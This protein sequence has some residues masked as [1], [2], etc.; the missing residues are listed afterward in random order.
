MAFYVGYDA[1]K[2]DPYC[3]KRV[4]A[5]FTGTPLNVLTCAPFNDPGWKNWI[6]WFKTRKLA[7]DFIDE[8]YTREENRSKLQ[9]Y[10]VKE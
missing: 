10:E 1:G 8:V 2:N 4:A 5:I 9:V 6:L 7:Q 3:G